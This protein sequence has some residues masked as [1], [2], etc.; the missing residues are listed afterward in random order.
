M[1]VTVKTKTPYPE[2]QQ[3][4]QLE[5]WAQEAISYNVGRV[6]GCLYT[7][8][9]VTPSLCS[10]NTN[11]SKKNSL[12]VPLETRMSE[13]VLKTSS[14]CYYT[15]STHSP[16]TWMRLKND[17]KAHSCLKIFCWENELCGFIGI[18]LAQNYF[19]W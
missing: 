19:Q 2:T 8:V 9:R 1:N 17:F 15:F 11:L 14:N 18:E 12:D 7:P 3:R 13:S 16:K 10:T 4:D 5:L 6:V